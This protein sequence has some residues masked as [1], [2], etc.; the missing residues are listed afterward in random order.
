MTQLVPLP[1]STE[2]QL[3]LERVGSIATHE[4]V[5]QASQLP[6]LGH[7]SFYVQKSVSKN[8]N[9]EDNMP[10]LRVPNAHAIFDGEPTKLEAFI[11]VTSLVF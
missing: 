5:F 4:L 1:A 3:S 7:K 11:T 9:K 2:E 8:I 6:P 10:T